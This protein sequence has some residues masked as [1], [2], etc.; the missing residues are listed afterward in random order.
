MHNASKIKQEWQK[1]LLIMMVRK[2][3]TIS[4]PITFCLDYRYLFVLV[5]VIYLPKLSLTSLFG[6]Q[7]E[8]PPEGR[9]HCTG[10]GMQGFR[11][12]TWK[13]YGLVGP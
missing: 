7:Y 1:R 13:L 4:T 10:T 9:S 8:H 3:K 12:I 11:E 2:A 5:S 6:L